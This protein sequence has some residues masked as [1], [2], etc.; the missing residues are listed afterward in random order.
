MQ[1]VI[2]STVLVELGENFKAQASRLG[3]T[4]EA[5]H[6]HYGVTLVIH[7]LGGERWALL[8]DHRDVEGPQAARFL[9][10]AML[11]DAVMGMAVEDVVAV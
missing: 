7:G 5:D 1:R 9:L 6:G 8:V 10:A 2:E 11:R 4:T 3:L